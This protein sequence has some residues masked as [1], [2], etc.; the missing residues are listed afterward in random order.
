M[1][2]CDKELTRPGETHNDLPHQIF[3]ISDQSFVCKMPNSYKLLDQSEARKRQ[4]MIRPGEY[5]NVST[6]IEINVLL[7]CME[8]YSNHKSVM[9]EQ[10]KLMVGLEYLSW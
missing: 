9:D 6:K 10:M 2:E 3:A 8:I 4:S 1:E 5:H 7:V